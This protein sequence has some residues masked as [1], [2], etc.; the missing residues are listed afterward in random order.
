MVAQVARQGG[1]DA[2]FDAPEQLVRTGPRDP[3]IEIA[4]S[5]DS[6]IS[7]A[8]R[9]REVAPQADSGTRTFQV[10]VGII[11][12]PEGLRLGSTVTGRI[13]LAPPAG[14]EV[15]ATALTQSKGGPAV[16]VVDPRSQTVSLRE[17]AVD[18]YEGANAVIA[19]G[20]DNG[21]LV[22]TAG[23]QTLRPDQKVRLL[24]VT[25]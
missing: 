18:R 15:P 7:A 11:D 19:R 13:R 25:S 14:V 12:P 5:D 1:L 21:D 20:L 2:V 22:V 9:I 16:W 10:K 24:G 23:V 8:G 4:L 3:A 17:V 6:R